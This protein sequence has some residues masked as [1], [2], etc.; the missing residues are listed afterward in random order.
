MINSGYRANRRET[1]GCAGGGRKQSHDQESLRFGEQVTA[2]MN[3]GDFKA[4]C[5]GI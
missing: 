3:E 1:E 4:I 5:S 2:H